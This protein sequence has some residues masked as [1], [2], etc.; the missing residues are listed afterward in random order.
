MLE[1]VMEL[2]QRNPLHVHAF[3]VIL[4]RKED[5]IWARLSHPMED[6]SFRRDKELLGL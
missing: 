2:L 6:S 3:S 1:R 4:D 5:L